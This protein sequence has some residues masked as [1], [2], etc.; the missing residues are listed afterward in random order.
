VDQGARAHGTRGVEVHPCGERAA[1]RLPALSRLRRVRVAARDEGAHREGG[2]APRPGGAREARARRH[3]RDRV[4]R[5]GVPA[6]PRGPGPA[7]ADAVVA[8]GAAAARGRQA[9]AGARRAGAGGGLSIPAAPREPAADARRRADAHD[10]GGSTDSRAHRV[11][12]GIRRLG[13]VRGGA[14]RASRA[15]HACVPGSHVRAPRGADRRVARRERRR[16]GV[17]AARRRPRSSRRRSRRAALP[18][19][20]EAPSC[21]RNSAARPRCADSMR[22][23]ARGSTCWCRG[24]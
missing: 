9:A 18:T 15:R 6:H 14:R 13:G 1:V 10:P 23:A 19:A 4:H 8:V 16:R 11:R 22:P 12:D 20:S 24:C 21:S 5:A 7:P 3:P 17:G 2:R